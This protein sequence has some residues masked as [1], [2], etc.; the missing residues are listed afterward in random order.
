LTIDDFVKSAIDILNDR[1][2]QA[3]ARVTGR[4][5]CAAIVRPATDPRFGD[6]QANGIMA[7]AK[8][9]KTNPRKLA[10]SVVAQLDISDICEPP[11]V[12]GPGFINLR[13][14]P[15]YV[16]AESLRIAGNKDRLGIEKDP[17]PQTVVVDFSS[18]NIAKQMHVGHLRSTIIGDAICR[19]FEFLGHQ[20]IRQNHIGDW[21][22]HFGMLV[23]KFDE[24]SRNQEK[25]TGVPLTEDQLR[26]PAEETGFPLVM[27]EDLYRQAKQRYDSDAQFEKAAKEAVVRLHNHDPQYAKLWQIIVDESR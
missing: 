6:Y 20:V 16:A 7:L 17:E 14:K 23:A 1:I 8:Q 18:P 9:I 12:A 19:L 3:M 22:T 25:Y 11:E 13:L 24:D 15:E 2:G 26:L 5:D 4:Q 27:F 21:G 10:E